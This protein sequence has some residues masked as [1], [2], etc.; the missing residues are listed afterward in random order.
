MTKLKY[1]CWSEVEIL[2][3]SLCN[4]YLLDNDKIVTAVVL[5]IILLLR[6]IKPA[7]DD[8]NAD[9]DDN[10]DKNTLILMSH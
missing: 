10:G 3:L 5:E 2:A 8:D 6:P 4:I 1:Y 9:D 7:Y